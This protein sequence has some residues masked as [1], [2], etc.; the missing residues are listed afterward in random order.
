MGW[1][2]GVFI[3]GAEEEEI[4]LGSRESFPSIYGDGRYFFSMYIFCRYVYRGS[5]VAEG[6][7]WWRGVKRPLI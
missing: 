4:K 1:L 7:R 5:H 2:E 3:G 6:G